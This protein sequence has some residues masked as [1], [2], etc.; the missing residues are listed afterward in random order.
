MTSQTRTLLAAALA[1][2]IAAPALTTPAEAGGS[3]AL[4]LSPRDAQQ[5]QLMDFGLRAYGLYNGLKNGG[6][7]IDQK[8]RGNSAGVA[9]NGSGNLGL[10]T[11]RGEGHEGT[12][13]QRGNGNSYG[14][15]QF[16]RGTRSAIT[17]QGNASTG[18]AV[19]FGW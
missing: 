2:L 12:I 13:D 19:T 17:Q 3:I 15:F 10:V 5:A 14:L 8:G 1:A 6:A 18:A 16:G 11:Q 4:T 7:R 9:Q